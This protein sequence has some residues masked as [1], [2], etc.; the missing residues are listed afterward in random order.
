MNYS[1]RLN[2]VIPGGAHTYSRG[3]DQYPIN[4]PQIFKNSKGS[5]SYTPEGEEFLD[6]SMGLRSVTLG[7]DYQEVSEAAIK[8]IHNGNTQSRASLV[9]LEAA[10]LFVDIIPSADMVKFAKNGSSATSA[11]VKV[12]RAYT[13]KKYIVRCVDHPFFSYDDWFIGDTIIKRGVPQEFSSLTLNFKFNDIDSLKGL[14][15]KYHNQIAGVILEPATTEHPRGL[16]KKCKR[17]LS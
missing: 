5:Y 11:A 2:R 15:E 3:D 9:E 6:Y 17:S 7:Y 1:D 8:Q 14:F 12:A 16:F 4:A 10:E 13:G